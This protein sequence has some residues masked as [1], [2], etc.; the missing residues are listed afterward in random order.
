MKLPNSESAIIPPEKLRDYI[1]SPIHPIGRF[2]SV[3]FR[4]LGYSA[5]A[6][7][8]LESDIRLLLTAEAEWA[9]VNKFGSKYLVRGLLSGPNG[10]SGL[11][12]TVWIILSGEVAPR[13]VT[14][15]PEG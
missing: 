12:V 4:G 14:A 1:L 10:R 2:K 13:F 8:R 6:F 7:E 15:Y 9:E 11:I 5:E 3:F